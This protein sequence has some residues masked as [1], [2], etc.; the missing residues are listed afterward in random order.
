[1]EEVKNLTQEEV[2]AISAEFT[3]KPMFNGVVITLNTEVEDGSLVLSD[4]IMSEEQFVVAAGYNTQHLEEGD[5]ITIDLEKMMVR[6]RNPHNTD[7]IITRIKVK[8]VY[9]KDYTFG[10]I[11]DRTINLIEKK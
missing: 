1:M 5:K 8:P 10:L 9:F 7:E 4:N 3:W 2:K 6:E 11:E